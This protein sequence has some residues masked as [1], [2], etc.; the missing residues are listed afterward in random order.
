[1]VPFNLRKLKISTLVGIYLTELDPSLQYCR[2]L[3]RIAMGLSKFEGSLPTELSL[4]S[5]LKEI[6][7][8]G[9]PMITGTTPSKFG[10]LPSLERLGLDG[11]GMVGE[12]PEALCQKAAQSLD[13]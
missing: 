9:N 12:I 7:V 2:K 8:S 1:M 4:L 10:L 3:T 11:T 5:S 13:I 6:D